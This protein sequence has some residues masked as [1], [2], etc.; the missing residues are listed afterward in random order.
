MRD[1]L[2]FLYQAA[3]SKDNLEHFLD[4]CKKLV[5]RNGR[6]NFPQFEQKQLYYSF[7]TYIDLQYHFEK[8]VF[9]QYSKITRASKFIDTRNR[10]GLKLQVYYVIN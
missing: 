6:I 9:H 3:V 1:R 5:T 7:N 10:I 2:H 8:C 4:S